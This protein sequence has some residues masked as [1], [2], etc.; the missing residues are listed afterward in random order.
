MSKQDKFITKAS[1]IHRGIYDYSQVE[2]INVDVK[3]EIICKDHGS[4]FQTPRIHIYKKGGCNKCAVDRS[5]KTNTKNTEQFI[6]ESIKIHNNKY[7]YSFVGYTTARKKVKIVCPIHGLFEQEPSS[8]T[9]GT[10]CKKC[11]VRL[12]TVSFV[13]KANNTHNDTYSYEQVDYITGKH[14]VDITCSV[15]GNFNQT[16]ESH[17]QGIGCPICALENKSFQSKAELEIAEFIKSKGFEVIQNTHSII[18]P[19]E[20]DIFIPELNM[21]IE[22]DGIYWHSELSNKPKSYHLDKTK[23]CNKKGIRLIHIFEHEWIHKK[24]LVLSRISN[25]LG[26]SNRIYARK[27][28][29]LEL[30]SKE[31]RP[32]LDVNHIQGGCPASIHLG[33]QYNDNI[34]AVMTFGKPRFSK[35]AEWELIRYSNIMGSSVVGGASRLFK[36]FIKINQPTNIISY[37]DIRWNTGNLYTQLGFEHIR[38]SAPNYFYFSRNKTTE[39]YSR[40]KFQKHK[41]EK[42]LEFFDPNLSEWEN[43]KINNYNRIWDCGNSVFV[44]NV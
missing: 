40:N 36:Y 29:I 15:H 33:L 34:V 35:T 26:Q 14:K 5:K 20:L 9:Q 21:A 25:I 1:T 24:D 12:D 13:D 8:H 39:L 37:S 31:S 23:E 11:A 42:I 18:P 2:Y 41:L 38:D 19:K 7:D 32:F 10:G 3:V 22:F 27:C 6:T 44:W 4:F 16:A 28:E 17:L 30:S 43:M